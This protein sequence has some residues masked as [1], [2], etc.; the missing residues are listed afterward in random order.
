MKKSIRYVVI[1]LTAVC[2]GF[3]FYCLAR[4]V[5]EEIL[6]PSTRWIEIPQ[7]KKTEESDGCEI[8]GRDTY[9]FQLA[10]KA[11]KN[12]EDDE[13]FYFLS[14]ELQAHPKNGYAWLLFAIIQ[15]YQEK[16]GEALTAAN[17]AIKY[18]PNKD[19]ERKS[20]A[21]NVR[22]EIYEDME[23][24]EKALADYS[25]AI[26]I[27]PEEAK[28]YEGRAD[29]YLSNE[30]YDLAD[31]DYRTM[32]SLDP[33][34]PSG[35]IGLGKIA[36]TQKSYEEAI[37]QFDY[38]IKL[39]SSDSSG[40]LHRAECHKSF[41]KYDEAADDAVKALSI[42]FTDAEA[43]SLMRSLADSAFTTIISKL[44]ALYEKDPDNSSYWAF[45]LGCVY[46]DVEQYS[47]AIKQYKKTG[48]ELAFI[49]NRI[50]HCWEGAG[51]QAQALEYINRA[52]QLDST[53][54]KYLL[55]KEEIEE[56][57]R[58]IKTQNKQNTQ[59]IC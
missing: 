19:S 11:F 27:L 47:N 38:I 55:Y 28:T 3:V 39:D 37:K 44:E 51:N 12:K 20:Y 8:G 45:C 29:F 15:N 35:Y 34:N 42:D 41:G 24:Y 46:E 43:F 21:F 17:K 36:T 10:M 4:I 7:N 5:T 2:V 58:L 40:H 33:G 50:A 52:I 6:Y 16:Y 48:E 53:E 1:A 25:E 57:A 26:K 49:C 14:E 59:R 30:E 54:T 22:G 32:I 23:D 31:K 56:Q 13:A 18:I 9:Y